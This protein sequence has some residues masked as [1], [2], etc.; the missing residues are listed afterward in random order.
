MGGL[1]NQLFQYAAARRL[2]LE[3]DAELALDLG[4]FRH[5]GRGLTTRRDFQLERLP[6][7]GRTIE[8]EPETIAR[9][10]RRRLLRGRN[11][12]TVL[13]QQ[14]DDHG[15]DE[16]VLA[17]PDGVLLIGYWQ[18]EQYFSA[19]ADT[20]RAEL[21][22]AG[23]PDHGSVALHVRRGDYVRVQSTRDFHGLLPLDYYKAALEY[24]TERVPDARVL[25]FSDEPE[26]VRE[27]LLPEHPISVADT[28]DAHEDFR[29]MSSCAHHVIANSSFSWWG[30]W[31]GERPGS[32]VVAPRRWFADERLDTTELVPERWVRL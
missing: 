8:I 30:A 11:G 18:S 1:G 13:R 20:L 17:A 23:E 16:R 31:L 6:I 10:E 14:P 19:V 24:V 7:A 2:A 22:P 28:G 25:A 9:W 26:W 15:V 3:H 4:W 27:H 5:E 12:L 29:L 21:A 32:I